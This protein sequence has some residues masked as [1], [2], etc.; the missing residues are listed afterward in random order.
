MLGRTWNR[1]ERASCQIDGLQG[2]CE[3]R[4]KL[5]SNLVLGRESSSDTDGVSLVSGAFP[6]RMDSPG[7]SCWSTTFILLVD[8]R[9]EVRLRSILP[10]AHSEPLPSLVHPALDRPVAALAPFV[11]S[12]SRLESRTFSRNI[13]LQVH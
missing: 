5:T 13:N 6:S 10:H 9:L 7:G 4:T 1:G 2:S 12:S 3:K 8:H 11:G